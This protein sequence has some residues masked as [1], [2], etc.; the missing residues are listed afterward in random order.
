MT[1]G[2]SSQHAIKPAVIDRRYRK[3]ALSHVSELLGA[4]DM[5]MPFR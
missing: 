5:T 4:L 1:A 2:F 3:N